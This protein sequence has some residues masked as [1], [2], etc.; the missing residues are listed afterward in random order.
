MLRMG[1]LTD[2][3]CQ[4]ASI[5]K[6]SGTEMKSDDSPRVFSLHKYVINII[7]MGVAPN[8]KTGIFIK[9]ASTGYATLKWRNATRKD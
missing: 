2:S 9:C 5:Q 4:I 8:G 7:S 3:S 6:G 1:M